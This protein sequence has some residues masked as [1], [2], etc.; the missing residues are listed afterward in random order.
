MS[1][2]YTPTTEDVRD[3]YREQ[4]DGCDFPKHQDYIDYKASGGGEGEFDRWLAEHD[5]QVAERAWEKGAIAG[6]RAAVL[7][8]PLAP[9]PYQAIV[10]AATGPTPGGLP[11]LTDAEAEAFLAAI[12]KSEPNAEEAD[13]AD[14]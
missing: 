14:H 2:D 6:H 13:R 3:A 11:G 1:D 5:R 7:P 9:N 10:E 12:D 8:E 4:S